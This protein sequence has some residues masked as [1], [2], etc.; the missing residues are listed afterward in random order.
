MLF[1][2]QHILY[3]V[4]STIVVAGLLV[5]FFFTIKS[6]KGKERTLKIIAILTVFFH[7]L[8]L[9][10]K[11]LKT[12]KA[13]VDDTLL[14]PIFPC[15]LAMWLLLIISFMDKN[16]KVFR[17]LAEFLF[18][19]GILGAIFGNLFNVYYKAN[20]TLTNIGTIKSLVSHTLLMLGCL[21]LLVGGFIKIRVRNVISGLW[22]LCLV[23][24]STCL[25]IIIYTAFNH[26]V[27]N[28]MG[29][30]APY[31]ESLPWLN[32]YL[33][34]GMGILLVFVFTVLYEQFA[35]KEENRWY[36]PLKKYIMDHKKK[37]TEKMQNENKDV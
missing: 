15:N 11:F 18:Y 35:L 26:P 5:L 22:G 19:F 3:M 25:V 20:P 10:Y 7:Y 29:I 9:Y 31:F 16:S 4:L 24:V 30:T 12:G 37:K 21:Y 34:C 1:D 28:I 23:L 33:I 36:Y 14:F 2:T 17:V 27:P 32:S 13:Y 8:Q 6:Q